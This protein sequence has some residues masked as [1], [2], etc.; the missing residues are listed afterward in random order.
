MRNLAGRYWRDSVG[1]VFTLSLDRSPLESTKSADLSFQETSHAQAVEIGT[2]N[3]TGTEAI[4]RRLTVGDRCFAIL[5]E[6]Q[7][8]VALWLHR[9]ECYVRGVDLWIRESSRSFY[10]YGVIT[11]PSERRKGHYGRIVNELKCLAIREGWQSIIQYV[12]SSN[13]IPQ[14]VLASSGYFHLVV[15]SRRRGCIR[16]VAV[17]DP[18][19]STCTNTWR[20]G[21]PAGTYLV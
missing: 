8:V 9:G 21:E 15:A 6:G 7:P 3:G 16:Q 11:K 1:Y 17:Y 14:T 10:C 12:E 13:T 2:W 18:A 20:M 4:K 19:T 5:K